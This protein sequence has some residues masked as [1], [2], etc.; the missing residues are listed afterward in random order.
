MQIGTIQSS[1]SR[2]NLF[3]KVDHDKKYAEVNADLVKPTSLIYSPQLKETKHTGFSTSPDSPAIPLNVRKTLANTHLSARLQAKTPFVTVSNCMDEENRN[4][5]KWEDFFGE[6]DGLTAYS[7]THEVKGGIEYTAQRG[8]SCEDA[9]SDHEVASVASN[10]SEQL[11]RIKQV[12]AH[13]SQ[14]A[15]SGMLA[16]VASFVDELAANMEHESGS[17]HSH[18]EENA[19]SDEDSFGVDARKSRKKFASALDVHKSFMER[20]EQRNALTKVK[21]VGSL[22]ALTKQHSFMASKK[23]Q[24]QQQEQLGQNGAGAPPLA[25]GT[26]LIRSVSIKSLVPSMMG[27]ASG[28][29]SVASGATSPSRGAEFLSKKASAGPFMFLSGLSG[30]KSPPRSPSRDSNKPAPQQRQLSN[31]SVSFRADTVNGGAS[32][33]TA[34]DQ[35]TAGGR[36]SSKG[37]RENSMK[38]GTLGSVPHSPLRSPGKYSASPGGFKYSSSRASPFFAPVGEE[39]GGDGG[40]GTDNGADGG[41]ALSVAAP[42]SQQG[43]SNSPEQRHHAQ[44]VKHQ[45]L[46]LFSGVTAKKPQVVD[47]SL[48]LSTVGAINSNVSTRNSAL[49]AKKDTQALGRAPPEGA[50]MDSVAETAPSKH[51]VPALQS[52][53]AKDRPILQRIDKAIHR[54]SFQPAPPK[55]IP[56]APKEPEPLSLHNVFGP[57][58]LLH[59][60]L[61]EGDQVADA[62]LNALMNSLTSAS[63]NPA[64]FNV[65]GDT[66]ELTP[67]TV[68]RQRSVQ[69]GQPLP[70]ADVLEPLERARR[71]LQLEA[72]ER[73]KTHTPSV[74]SAAQ[75]C[76][77]R[78][79]LQPRSQQ[80]QDPYQQVRR[81]P[82]LQLPMH[83]QQPQQQVQQKPPPE[84]PQQ[85]QVAVQRPTPLRSRAPSGDAASVSDTASQYSMATFVPRVAGPADVSHPPTNAPPALD[86]SGITPPP[87]RGEVSLVSP[88][89]RSEHSHTP[90]QL[91][92]GQAFDP[93]HGA[94]EY[95]I[96]LHSLKLPDVY[97][98]AAGSPSYTNPHKQYILNRYPHG[99]PG[100]QSRSAPILVR[101]LQPPGGAPG[102][103]GGGSAADYAHSLAPHTQVYLSGVLA[104]QDPAHY[105][106]DPHQYRAFSPNSALYAHFKDQET[107]EKELFSM[108]DEDDRNESIKVLAIAANAAAK[109]GT[110]FV[111]HAGTDATGTGTGMRGKVSLAHNS[112]GPAQGMAST[113][114]AESVFGSNV[115]VSSQAPQGYRYQHSTNSYVPTGAAGMNLSQYGN[116][117][118]SPLKQ[119]HAEAGEQGQGAAEVTF[120]LRHLQAIEESTAGHGPPVIYI[121]PG[122]PVAE[123]RMHRRGGGGGVSVGSSSSLYP[124]TALSSLAHQASGTLAGVS[125][126]GGGSGGPHSV[127]SRE[128]RGALSAGQVLVDHQY[129]PVRATMQH[130]DEMAPS[131]IH[132][133][134]ARAAA[135]ADEAANADLQAGL[136]TGAWA[137]A[138]VK[139]GVHDLQQLGDITDDES[140]GFKAEQFDIKHQINAYIDRLASSSSPP[141][142]TQQQRSGG[143]DDDSTELTAAT[144]LSN[145][146]Q[147]AARVKLW[148]RLHG[149][150]SGDNEGAHNAK[151]KMRQW[152]YA[153]VKEETQLMKEYMEEMDDWVVP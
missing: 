119:T 70:P 145:A 20:A 51:H 94:G 139:A 54:L 7:T 72:E 81:E 84:Q 116:Y 11:E 118:R 111:P 46:P 89:Q 73:R 77:D 105:H 65:Y 53:H 104:A 85:H 144:G 95:E 74:Y 122:R 69:K 62:E 29:E 138:E 136:A 13:G 26:D 42:F 97:G 76:G 149:R 130:P 48:S 125:G 4:T 99:L 24:Q 121:P 19:S 56:Q 93:Q 131:A 10:H 6:D 5:K 132:Y 133:D 109:D 126:G 117:E 124:L 120:S 21:S 102:S 32:V 108:D 80:Q 61:R 143:A 110:A 49:S 18:D 67:R 3:A 38:G 137:G 87:N 148:S 58:H 91:G 57:A 25:I 45:K 79:K 134:P 50:A 140:R 86:F 64:H 113:A 41:D 127:L 153:G 83:Q 103:A 17:E 34:G 47:N 43:N 128:G 1:K 68:A 142:S 23:Q 37:G 40:G 36:P 147:E 75:L 98:G 150:Y 151:Q 14:K 123:P 135:Q 129:A 115:P 66:R 31:K 152:V 92:E 106:T 90:R 33:L 8:E 82:S 15:G 59:A 88:S 9:G 22:K 12:E 71:Q 2:H 146:Q 55:P 141:R 39:E 52:V 107:I 44:Y 30:R 112:N 27:G 96:Q 28:G 100:Q 16:R 114:K 78:D 35:S 63:D 101:S 60:N